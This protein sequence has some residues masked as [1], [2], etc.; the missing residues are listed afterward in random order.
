MP[1]LLTFNECV[2]RYG[3]LV[4]TEITIEQAIQEA[5]DA[6]YEMGRWPGTTVELEV[7]ASSFVDGPNTQEKYLQLDPDL[8]D[9]VVGFRNATGGYG[10]QDQIALYRV[11]I[12]SGDSAFIDMGRVDYNGTTV[13]RYR[14]P[15]G[16]NT[17]YPLWALIKKCAPVFDPGGD[18]TPVPVVSRNALKAAILAVCYATQNDPVREQA[19]WASFERWMIAGER[20]FHGKKQFNIGMDSSLKRRPRQFR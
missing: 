7:S 20:Q 2:T 15:L 8:Y 17:N 14:A 16:W 12:N 13:R 6:I 19:E 1:S 4:T 11:G 5:V 9:G 3:P 18:D 10:I